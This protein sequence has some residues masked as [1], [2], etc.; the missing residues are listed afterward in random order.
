MPRNIQRL[1]RYPTENRTP[2]MCAAGEPLPVFYSS[3]IF[4]AGFQIRSLKRLRHIE[5]QVI[6]E[7]IS[8]GMRDG[9]YNMTIKGRERSV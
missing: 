6:V 8:I 4:R 7:D 1:H 2:A 3:F 5:K 9:E